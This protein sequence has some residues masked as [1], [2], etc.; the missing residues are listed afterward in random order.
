MLTKKELNRLEKFFTKEEG[1]S[2]NHDKNPLP[3]DHEVV[4]IKRKSGMTWG[5][6]RRIFTL[7]TK[8]K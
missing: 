3:D 5:A 7:G 6:L 8:E 4:L 1:G 2:K